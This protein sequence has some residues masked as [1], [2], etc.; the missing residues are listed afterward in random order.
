MAGVSK[1]PKVLEPI[2]AHPR[3]DWLRPAVEKLLREEL[4]ALQVEG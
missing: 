2:V 3:H 1:F 4:A